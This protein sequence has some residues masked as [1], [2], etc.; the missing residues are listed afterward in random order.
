MSERARTEIRVSDV[1]PEML[2]IK[3]LGAALAPLDKTSAARVIGWAD[4]RYG[5][6]AQR[7]E[8]DQLSESIRDAYKSMSEG[9]SL[10]TRA[11]RELNVPTEQVEAVFRRIY[12]ETC[13][14]IEAERAELVVDHS[15]G[16]A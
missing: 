10:I 13:A 11:V 4:K 6:G 16:E 1:D 2:A 12:T 9:L 5:V 14:Q 15:Y 7:A 8:E 3:A